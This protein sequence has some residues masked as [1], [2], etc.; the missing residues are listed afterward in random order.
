M[1]HLTTRITRGSRR[2]PQVAFFGALALLGA[3][4]ASAASAYDPGHLPLH[5][6]GP[7]LQGVQLAQAPAPGAKTGQL[8]S[9]PMQRATRLCA[10]K[11]GKASPHCVSALDLRQRNA[12][13]AQGGKPQPVELDF[14][15]SSRDLS[16]LRQFASGGGAAHEVEICI[17]EGANICPPEPFELV[18]TCITT[19]ML[20][21]SECPEPPEHTVGPAAR[22][23]LRA[24]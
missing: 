8:A 16:R 10:A 24:K 20:A 23:K 17:V 5:T 6:S 3:T 1:Q 7:G 19:G 13:A 14:Q 15:V 9:R 12:P 21:G 11:N 4:A 22:V 18:W 2:L